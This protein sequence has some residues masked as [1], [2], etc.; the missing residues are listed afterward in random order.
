MKGVHILQN[1]L[2]DINIG[3]I[4]C[5]TFSLRCEVYIEDK[6]HRVAFPNEWNKRAIK[7]LN[8][9]HFDV[10]GLMR[11]T[12]MGN[13]RYFVTFIDMFSRKMWLYVLK[14]KGNFF[15]KFKQFKTFVETQLEH[16]I[17]IFSQKMIFNYF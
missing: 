11:T 6:Q 17:N 10:C 13:T 3:K 16:K 15:E 4:S 8:V 14:S 7:P 5:F 9:V 1:M 2:S 12:S